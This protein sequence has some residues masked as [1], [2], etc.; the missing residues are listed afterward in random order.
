MDKKDE[1]MPKVEVEKLRL[2]KLVSELYEY[3]KH[4]TEGYLKVFTVRIGDTI[5]MVPS[6]VNYRLN[7]LQKQNMLN[8]VYCQKVEEIR[9]R[10]NDFI[11]VTKY[12][13]DLGSF[14]NDTWFLKKEDAEKRLKEMEKEC[15]R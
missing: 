14:E 8:R 1:F 2:E 5:Y 15:L 7:K 6:L 13:S 9:I 11:I 3:R 12:C 10:E 4:E